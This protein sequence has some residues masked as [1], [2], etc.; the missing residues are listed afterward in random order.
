M[1]GLAELQDNSWFIFALHFVHIP[2]PPGAF[3]Q[4]WQADS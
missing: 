1:I 4:R 3:L 2:K